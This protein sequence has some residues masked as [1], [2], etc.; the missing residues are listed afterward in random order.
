MANGSPESSTVGK[1]SEI[2]PRA[3][4]GVGAS[5]GGLEAF[6]QLIST[7][8][9][10]H[11]HAYVIVQHLDPDHESLLPELLAKRTPFDVVSIEDGM[12]IEGG[13]IYLIPPGAS[14]TVQGGALKLM[15]FEE[16]RGRRRPIDIF[17]ASL[18]DAYRESCAAI[19]L[20]GTGSDG[21]AGIAAVKEK[22]GLVFVQDPQQAKYDGMP[23]SAIASGAVDLVLP[24][25]EMVA[26]ID[27]YFTRRLGIEP[28]IEND[29]DFLQ[30]V[31][32]HVRYRTGHDFSAYKKA[33][34]MRR[35]SRR[36]SVLG[37]DAPASYLQ[38]LISDQEEVR[39]LFKDLLINV[40]SFFRDAPTFE[41]LR[42]CC[43]CP[44]IQH[45]GPDD[46][47]RI[48]APGCSTGQE[49][50]SLAMLVSDELSRVH[51]RAKVSI[52]ATDI[53]EDA[54]EV[55]RR[56]VYPGSLASEIPPDLFERYCVGDGDGF[57]IADPVREMVRISKHNLISDPPFSKIDLVSCRNLLIYFEPDLQRELL[58]N[59]H[60]ALKEGGHLF[61]GTSE[62]P[63]Q[64]AGD[65]TPV[66]TADRIYQRGRGP[67]RPLQLPLRAQSVAMPLDVGG[68][69]GGVAAV[70]RSVRYED[71]VLERH[72][73]PY[74]VVN[75]RRDIVFASRGTGA[76]LEL[77]PGAPRLG[78]LQMAH[79]ALRPPLRG[80][81]SGD[82]LDVGGVKLREFSGEIDGRRRQLVLTL[83]RIADNEHLIVF[84]DRLDI[85]NRDD[86]ETTG[87]TIGATEDPDA[88][89]Y[90][91]D[92]ERQLDAAQQTIR[93]TVEELETSNE[94][95]KS[96]NEEM[97]SMNEELQ[98]ANEELTTVNDE[99]NDK[100]RELNDKNDD[101]ANFVNSSRL[102]LLFLDSDL[103]LREF[104]PSAKHY[105]LV[106]EEDK[107][108]PFE[109]VKSRLKAADLPEKAQQVLASGDG[110]EFE[111]ETEDG[112]ENLSVRLSPYRT[113][114][115]G[116]SGVVV[117][118]FP[119]TELRQY[120]RRLEVARREA[121]ERQV[122]IEELYRI[123]PQAMS[124]LDRD[125]RYLRVNE[126]MAKVHGDEIEDLVG[127]SA[128]DLLPQVRKAL[129][130]AAKRVL[131]T[132]EPVMGS[133]VSGVIAADSDDERT[134][135][136]DWYPVRRESEIYAIGVNVT[137][138][139]EHK[140]LE[141]QL[142]ELMRELQHRVKNMLGNVISLVNQA[143]RDPRDPHMVMQTLVD[144][145]RALSSTHDLLTRENWGPANLRAVLDLELTEVYGPE[146]L[147]MRGPDL[148]I[149]ARGALGLGM[150]V[151]ELATNAA[152]YGALST[153]EGKLAVKWSRV[154]DGDG[155]ML[156]FEWRE[157]GGP[158]VER[159]E[160]RGFG[161]TLI[162]T[163]I[164]GSLQGSLEQKFEPSGY[165]CVVSIPIT[166]LN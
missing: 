108:R 131:E 73:A 154:D 15:S 59:F 18:A 101:L 162:L 32:K 66:S 51:G 109:H 57:R 114:T 14:L 55:A 133:E 41:A 84:Q 129:T 5:A 86:G 74:V 128:L 134:W 67:S 98:S 135:I 46:D 163:T 157:S 8:S 139:T 61:L 12:A 43:I 143:T 27:E 20:S 151:H 144:R 119:V 118:A 65:F 29:S 7:I 19:I 100:I 21:S 22:G 81:L 44:L 88:S 75:E 33:T 122:E 28:L 35:V 97:M 136:V 124:L 149:N 148:M 141:R 38:K 132:G 147:S 120:A 37:C 165:A 130:E 111:S 104:T 47:I 31:A 1:S 23:N 25:A 110:V 145:I 53:D 26:V 80:L 96:S 125:L 140:K 10:H 89:A 156:I 60:Y 6:Q 123:S 16:P 87:R 13:R 78:L 82:D 152:K 42:E 127:R 103:G 2:G 36:M 56:A 45:R 94:E 52:F 34:M 90:I 137:D 107:G 153:P 69:T 113:A 49:A 93:T 142:R 30:R 11:Q 160:A 40:T 105:F 83:E 79:P 77:T 68:P 39:L 91:A 4:I 95:L 48:W 121:K 85:R 138:V 155:D 126:R 9:P 58:P 62:T 71:V 116:V 164:E 63:A 54:L 115:G 17:F 50:Y 112:K 146:R 24:A 150:A 166:S 64:M 92:L 106:V 76:Y 161:S 3:V 70:D 99:L 159:P 102:A 72:V 158:A 117:V